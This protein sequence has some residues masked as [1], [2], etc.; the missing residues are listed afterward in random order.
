MEYQNTRGCVTGRLIGF[1]GLYKV[2]FSTLSQPA[3][4][5]Y[6]TSGL[7]DRGRIG[8]LLIFSMFNAF[9]IIISNVMTGPASVVASVFI[10][11]LLFS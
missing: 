5:D 1:N 2:R 6:N 10:S 11:H 8:Y 3:V 7:P 4:G 9:V